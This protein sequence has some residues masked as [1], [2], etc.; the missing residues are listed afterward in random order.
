MPR[1]GAFSAGIGLGRNGA[2]DAEGGAGDDGA[3]TTIG[4]EY[5]EVCVRG[6]MSLEEW[7]GEESAVH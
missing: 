1:G 3:L 6:P 2:C 5:P 7:R 4:D